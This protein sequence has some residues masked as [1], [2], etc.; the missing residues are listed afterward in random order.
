VLGDA[1][2]IVDCSLAPKLYHLETG[3]KAFKDNAIDLSVEF[4]AVRRYMD[5]MFAQPSFQSTRYDPEVIAWG[6]G[7]A[8]S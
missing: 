3:L 8:R 1:V 6:W 4:P 7:N 2:T 5:F